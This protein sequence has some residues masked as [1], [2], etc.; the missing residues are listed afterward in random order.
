MGRFLWQMGIFMP[1][2]R[3]VWAE[4]LRTRAMRLDTYDDNRGSHKLHF[5]KK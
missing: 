1:Y 3:D 5:D 4:Q 2:V